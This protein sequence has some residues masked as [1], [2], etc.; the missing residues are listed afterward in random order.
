MTATATRLFEFQDEKS[1]KFW[2]VT[3]AGTTV[4]VRYGKIGT[5]GQ[6]QTKE[7]AD[8]AAAAKHVAKLVAEKTGKGYVESGGVTTAPA[9]AS[10]DVPAP[11]VEGLATEPAADA[12]RQKSSSSRKAAPKN[13]AKD[14]D[15]SPESLLPLL[16]QDDATNRMLAKHPNASAELL[17]KLSHSSD[18]ATRKAV[19]LNPNADK[20]VLLRLAPQFPGDFFRNPVFDWLLLEDPNL[21]FKLGQGVL[22]NIL[23]RPDCPLSFLQWAASHGSEQEQLAVAMNP[24]A[25]AEVI[26]IL[27]A[28]PGPV[29]DAARGRLKPE[30][31]AQVD[32][33]QAFRDEVSKALA[34][35][36]FDEFK[37]ARK[38]GLVGVAQWPALNFGCRVAMLDPDAAVFVLGLLPDAVET[39]AVDKGDAIR[40]VVAGY[41]ATP[42]E[43]F[44]L[45][46]QDKAPEVRAALGRNPA[47]PVDIM[48][49]LVA[50]ESWEVRKALAGNPNIPAPLLSKLAAD[51]WFAVREAVV[52]S[53]I[54]TK[55]QLGTIA[56]KRNEEYWLKRHAKQRLETLLAAPE[57]DPQTP[58]EQLA[59]LAL[60]KKAD[61][62]CA[63]AANP[64]TPEATLRELAAKA[65]KSIWQALAR[66]PH[67]PADL[68]E[69][70]H[71]E[72][73]G[74]V[75]EPAKM[76]GFVRNPDCPPVAKQLAAAR[77]WQSTLQSC[78]QLLPEEKRTKLQALLAALE[79]IDDADRL[80]AYRQDCTALLE[81]PED[82][83]FG[84][85]CGGLAVDELELDNYW[86]NICSSSKARA[87][88]LIG[89][90]HHKVDLDKL[91][92]RSKSTDWSERLAIAR[93]PSTPL[94]LLAT[95][96][97]DPHALVALQAQATE[98]VKALDM[99]RQK[100]TLAS[101]DGPI[102][103]QPVV[104]AICD[105]LRLSCRSWQ[106][107]GTRWWDQL[108]IGRRL[109]KADPLLLL[110]SPL[111][112]D[113]MASSQEAWIRCA[114]ASSPQASAELLE[115]LA[116]DKND[117]VRKAA[118]DNLQ[119]RFPLQE[120]LVKGQDEGLSTVAAN[121]QTHLPSLEEQAQ[122][123]DGW[124]R[125]MVAKNPQT[126]S[127]L[128]EILAK[129][130]NWM[131]RS[132]VA[133][134]P[135]TPL[136]LLEMLAQ[137]KKEGVRSGVANNPHC[138][139]P[140]LEML[141]QDKQEDV[142]RAVAR[143][144][145]TPLPLLER[146]AQDKKKG[147]RS[148]VAENPQT[149]LP[150]LEKLAQD[151]DGWVC[152]MVVNHP[153]TSLP[154]LQKL[155]QHEDEGVRRMMAENSQTP[156]PLLEFLAQD[157]QEGVRRSV[158]KNPQI[159]LLLLENLAQDRDEWVRMIVA[160]TSQATVPLLEKLAQDKNAWVRSTV[161]ENPK[162]PLNLLEMLAS[163][164]DPWVRKAVAENPGA[165]FPVLEKLAQ[166]ADTN[167]R[168]AV[169]KNTASPWELLKRLSDDK[170]A[171][172]ANH[173][174]PA[175]QSERYVEHM[176]RTAGDPATAPDQLLTL[177][178]Q[179]LWSIRAAAL[180]NPS[181]SESDRATGLETLRA[182][183]EA[184]L[185]AAD[186]PPPPDE[187]DLQDIPVALQTMDLM[188]DPGDKKWMAA[189]A[190]SNFLLVR[191]G[192]I[193]TPGIQPSLLRMLLDDE[194]ETVRQLA[195]CKLRELEAAH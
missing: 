88:R 26:E 104:E 181:L 130:E 192:A 68:Y 185:R 86:A 7:L 173:C 4:T 85:A 37:S 119:A 70:A 108:S 47:C 30:T 167:V 153:R 140:L 132:T 154:L 54:L 174:T 19:C 65:N 38:R 51:W 137:D 179:G 25:P 44:T 18:Q 56:R 67:A 79:K 73:I 83:Q 57:T 62:R 161:A 32:L 74:A 125:T 151:Q 40:A 105:R 2:E 9:S 184:A 139:L 141:A 123:K 12:P 109:G 129:D 186:T 168:A 191:V 175:Y 157:K 34:E 95:L 136:P 99:A 36:T 146:L 180:N 178:S 28:K 81:H 63:V 33:D 35:M 107:A 158:A 177:A 14:P 22:K 160:K 171:S 120:Q 98:Q 190:K 159:P 13:P 90:A 115:V 145:Q 116:Q 131:V 149:P 142:R 134:Q 39:L 11:S 1:A 29:A 49:R 101:T 50:D 16:D 82:S 187:I 102:N 183:M 72:C 23:K 103:L 80:T 66:N 53:A 27:A 148:G 113:L 96:K 155:A 97:K 48:N 91:V 144:P 188:P 110:Q 118:A 147:V 162:T 60:S 76:R 172:V 92:K 64:S 93:N 87:I 126:P 106:I 59:A 143:N 17:E 150:L 78:D 77:L 42:P 111:A 100:A 128:L 176:L 24:N 121:H 194:V 84:R 58:V 166:D 31:A 135:Q 112:P 163:D 189:A 20:A 3:T 6:S 55:D 122:H 127:S 117:A 156:L 69:Q 61:V 164:D 21:L 41:Q 43:I 169:A 114:A 8:A 195:A 170:N 5:A 165:S 71:L 182:E 94:N 45:L 193:L 89:L 46:A 124:V 52:T 15:A 138:A 133:E 75:E 10:V 152:R